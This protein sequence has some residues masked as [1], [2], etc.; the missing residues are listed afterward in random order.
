MKE[1]LQIKWFSDKIIDVPFNKG[2]YKFMKIFLFKWNG[3]TYLEM[4]AILKKLY[5]FNEKDEE[6]VKNNAMNEI[7]RIHNYNKL[8][9]KNG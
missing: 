5:S 7:I 8:L 6:K 1:D 9:N 4:Y 2:L 3:L